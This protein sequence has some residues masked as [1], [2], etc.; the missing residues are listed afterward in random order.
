MY[1]YIIDSVSK[2]VN[3]ILPE[4]TMEV[5]ERVAPR[6]GRSQFISKAVMYYVHARGKQSLRERLKAGYQARAGESLKIAAEWFPLEEE[7][8]A[9][10]NKR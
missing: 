9:H 3:I 10:T 4:S 2:R 8:A 1:Q 7:T 5:L 6:G